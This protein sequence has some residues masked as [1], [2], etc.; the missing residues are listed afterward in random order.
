[1]LADLLHR[2][3]FPRRAQHLDDARVALTLLDESFTLFGPEM[4]KDAQSVNQ[5]HGMLAN[6]RGGERRNPPRETRF[7][8]FDEDAFFADDG[9]QD[10]SCFACG[11]DGFVDA[12]DEDPI[13][14][15]PGTIVI[16]H[17]C[18]GSGLASDQVVW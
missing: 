6:L 15:S 7:G 11:G 8:K 18:G 16:C 2:A 5:A 10:E 17:N 3:P 9:D 1:M 4:Y 14:E 13:N 12:H